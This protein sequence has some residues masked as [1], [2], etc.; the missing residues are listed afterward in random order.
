MTYNKTSIWKRMISLL[1]VLLMISSVAMQTFALDDDT[2]TRGETRD[3]TQVINEL[4]V[5]VLDAT[6]YN[7]NTW[8]ITPSSPAKDQSIGYRVNYSTSGAGSIDPDDFEIRIPIRTIKNRDGEWADTYEMSVP[9]GA[10]VE[11]FPELYEDEDVELVYRVEGDE[12]VVYNIKP[13]TAG[14][15]GYVEV[16]YRTTER[17]FN[18]K[19]IDENRV[20]FIAT[21]SLL[22]EN[23]MELT[24]DPIYGVFSTNAVIK[25]VEKRFPDMYKSWNSSWGPTPDDAAD[26][27]YL[28]WEI[29]TRIDE[30]A[31]QPYDFTLTDTIMSSTA[32][33]VEPYAYRFAGQSQFSQNNTITN[34][35]AVG[36]RYD[37]VITRQP[38]SVYQPLDYWAVNNKITATVHPIDGK[39]TDT[40]S[41]ATR[42]FTYRK[43]VFTPGG[44]NFGIYKRG[45]A[46]YRGLDERVKRHVIRRLSG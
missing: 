1:L 27:I 33:S 7:E 17:T 13:M 22:N 37:Y 15:N 34:Q 26:Y 20:P 16:L 3:R 19:D 42:Q 5:Q 24:S 41:S 45:D 18:Y 31:T 32:G 10:E 2:Q 35:T 25:G 6:Q 11:E 14:Q 4:V 43:A 39:K 12:I 30:N 21:A 46:Y 9:L 29:K 8:I 23:A 40:S 28:L 38:K 36:F 44:G